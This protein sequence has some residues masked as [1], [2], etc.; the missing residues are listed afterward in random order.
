MTPVVAGEQPKGWRPKSWVP[1]TVPALLLETSKNF[2]LSFAMCVRAGERFS[3]RGP[4][5]GFSSYIV[6]PAVAY[7]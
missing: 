1:L 3:Y 2:L 4:S 5:Q 7:C 6:I